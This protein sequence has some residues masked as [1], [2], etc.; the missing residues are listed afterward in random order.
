MGCLFHFAPTT[1]SL[2]KSSV[3]YSFEYPMGLIGAIKGGLWSCGGGAVVGVVL[4]LASECLRLGRTVCSPACAKLLK[5]CSSVVC[6][7]WYSL[8]SNYSLMSSI[9]PKR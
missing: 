6:D 4:R 7:T 1:S 8:M 3:L 9:M 5:I 2:E